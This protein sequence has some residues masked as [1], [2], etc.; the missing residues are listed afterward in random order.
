M[1]FS[2]QMFLCGHVQLIF[3]P[4]SCCKKKQEKKRKKTSYGLDT[5]LVG[6]HSLLLKH[7]RKEELIKVLCFVDI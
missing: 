1:P 7:K 4:V 5:A 3:V 2:Q 6:A